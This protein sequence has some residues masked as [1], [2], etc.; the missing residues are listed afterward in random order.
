MQVAEQ[1]AKADSNSGEA[2]AYLG[3]LK[4]VTGQVEGAVNAYR[5][6]AQLQPRVSSN[7]YNLGIAYDKLAAGSRD[8]KIIEKAVSAYSQAVKI[9][10]RNTAARANLARGYYN[11]GHFGK[12]A[13]SF[14]AAAAAFPTAAKSLGRWSRL[15]AS[16][17]CCKGFRVKG[18]YLKQAEAHY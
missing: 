2:F 9:D 4:F 5:R 8:P 1:A 11:L 18:T 14:R 17:C 10:P 7:Y 12:A 13:E 16:G 6:A 15:C 3:S